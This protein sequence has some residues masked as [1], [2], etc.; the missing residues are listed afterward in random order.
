[1]EENYELI[2]NEVQ[3][4]YEFHIDRHIPLIEYII[5]KDGNVYLTHTEVPRALGGRGIGTQLVEKTLTDIENHGFKV[6]PLCPF[7]AGYIKKNPEWKRLV[8]DG[9][10]IR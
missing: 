7:V 5:N 2:N 6:V 8:A 10:N 3:K 1:M 4:Q 9:I